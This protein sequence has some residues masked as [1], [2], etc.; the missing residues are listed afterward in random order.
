[1]TDFDGI[2]QR[3]VANAGQSFATVRGVTFQYVINGNAVIPQHTGYPLHRSQF[4]IA[5]DM[6]PVTGPGEL[7]QIVR[8]SA[9]VYAILHDSRVGPVNT[10]L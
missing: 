3:I 10:H 1:M 7:S 5:A 8:G 9:Y 6:W 2:W 4:K